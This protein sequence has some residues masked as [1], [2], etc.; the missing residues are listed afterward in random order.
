MPFAGR[1]KVGEVAGYLFSIVGGVV[2]AAG[3]FLEIPPDVVALRVLAWYA[4]AGV[5]LTVALVLVMVGTRQLPTLQRATLEGL[6]GSVPAGVQA[7]P[8]TAV[9]T[10]MLSQ[11]TNSAGNTSSALS[12][13]AELVRVSSRYYER[14]DQMNS[15]RRNAEASWNC[16]AGD[17]FS[18][19]MK[20]G[21]DRVEDLEK[22]ATT[23]A[24]DLNDFASK[25]RRCQNEMSDIRA[26]ARTAELSVTDFL[27]Q[28]PGPGPAR[29]PDDFTGTEPEVARHDQLVRE[30]DA[31]QDKIRAY[32]HASREAARID[33]QYATASRS[34]QSDYT[35]GQHASWLLSTGDILGSGA[36]AAVGV[37]IGL[38][39]SKLNVSACTCSTKPSV[40]RR[41]SRPTPSA[42]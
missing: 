22:A 31:H 38:K 9:I 11:V 41:T 34:L 15:T 12:G 39:Q 16:A 7:G 18:G 1:E 4:L 33:R 23:M 10:S 32:N 26:D 27:I 28:D 42:T 17:E 36:E 37:Q 25:L 13:A 30:Y 20:K 2:L 5:A 35:V 3:V 14:A 40:P 29:P 8:M 6:E 24:E 21:R 19:C